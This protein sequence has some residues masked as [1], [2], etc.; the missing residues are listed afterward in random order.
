MDRGGALIIIA[1]MG[2]LLALSGLSN[3]EETLIQYVQVSRR[4]L[5]ESIDAV[6]IHEAQPLTKHAKRPGLGKR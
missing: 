4:S 6:V 2:A 3:E 5:T 1:I